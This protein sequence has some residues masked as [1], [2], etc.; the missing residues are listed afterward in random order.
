MWDPYGSVEHLPVALSIW[1]SRWSTR[2]K[3]W[4]WAASWWTIYQQDASLDFRLTDEEDAVRGPG[5][6][7]L[8]HGHHSSRRIFS[9]NA[10]TLTDDQPREMELDYETNPG[11]NLHCLQTQ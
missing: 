11:T 6:G 7:G 3:P 5:G 4:T 9:A 2:A 8:L 10:A 1:T